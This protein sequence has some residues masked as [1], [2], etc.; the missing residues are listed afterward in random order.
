VSEPGPVQNQSMPTPTRVAVILLALLGVLLLAN[1]VLTWLAQETVVD[2][3]VATGVDRDAAAQSVLLFMIAYAIVG[4]TSLLAAI[5]LPRRRA[6]ARQ[7]GVLTTSLLVV[8]TLI[9]V[10]T[11]GGISPIG[12]LV[13]VASIAGLTSTLSRQTRDWVR[14]VVPTD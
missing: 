12:L 8:M 11:G 13:L 3:I 10:A 4:V 5:F 1:A 7:L 9:S 14:G 2:Q 6:W